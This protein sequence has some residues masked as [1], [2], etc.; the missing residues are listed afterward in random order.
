L[1]VAAT[2]CAAGANIGDGPGFEV[3]LFCAVLSSGCLFVLWLLVALASGAA[4]AITID[5][6]LGTGVRIGGWLAGTGMVLGAC[7]AGDWISLIVTLKDFAKYSWPAVTFACGFAIFERTIS[8]RPSSRGPN[9]TLSFA[10]ASLMACTG[11][12]Y[13]IWIG[14]R[15]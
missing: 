2:C 1:T 4:D 14:R 13:A 8:R 6:D 11:A 9:R 3:V 10:A 12:L 7:V 5:R 15:G